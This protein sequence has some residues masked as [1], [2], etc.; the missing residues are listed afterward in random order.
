M[1][2]KDTIQ[3]RKLWVDLY[4]I[5]NGCSVCGYNKHPAALCF[6]HLPGHEKAEITKNGCSKRS[7]AGGMFMLYSKKYDIEELISEIQK[8]RL[9]CHNCHM[10]HTHKN[11]VEQYDNKQYR[12]TLDELILHLREEKDAI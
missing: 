4:K 6:D 11:Q 7:C 1:N 2:N 10:E 8:C 12:I 9:V 5:T 3:H